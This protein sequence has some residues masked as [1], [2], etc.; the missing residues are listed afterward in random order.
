MPHGLLFGRMRVESTVELVSRT[1]RGQLLLENLRGRSAYPAEAQAAEI[2]LRQRTGMLGLDDYR[3]LEIKPLEPQTW[4]V[5]FFDRT[6]GDEHSVH[7]IVEKS[8]TAIYES[9]ALDKQTPLTRF[10]STW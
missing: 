9:C 8:T 2:F 3:L 7:I 4:Q 1:R 10:S 5:N 6:T